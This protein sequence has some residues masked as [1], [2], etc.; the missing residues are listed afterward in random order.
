MSIRSRVG[1]QWAYQSGDRADSAT[2]QCQE[3]EAR[4]SNHRHFFHF[5]IVP[6][7]YQF[8]FAAKAAC[9]IS[10]LACSSNAFARAAWPFI[11]S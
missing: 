10:S 6:F 9:L 5:S 1:A 3:S 2:I 7:Y 4:Q 11:S 8:R